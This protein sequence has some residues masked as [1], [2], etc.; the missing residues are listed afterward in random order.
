MCTF[1]QIPRL[2]RDGLGGVEQSLGHLDHQIYQGLITFLWGHLKN[3]D[4]V[5]PLDSQEDIVARISEAAARMREI[6]GIFEHIRQS[7]HQRSQECIATGG[8][9]FE[10]LL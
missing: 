10:Q 8:R 6:S 1:K 9:N 2:E 7:L 5:L 4:Y 3:L